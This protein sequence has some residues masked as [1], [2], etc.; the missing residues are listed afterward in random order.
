MRGGD[1]DARAIAEEVINTLGAQGF[2]EFR[3]L[4]DNGRD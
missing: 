4:L 3:D 2:L 1:D